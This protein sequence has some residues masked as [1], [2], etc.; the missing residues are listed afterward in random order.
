MK[1]TLLFLALIAIVLSVSA[2]SKE[3]ETLT[4]EESVIPSK[5]SSDEDFNLAD[6]QTAAAP[7]ALTTPVVPEENAVAPAPVDNNKTMLSPDKQ[8]NLVKEYSQA[9]IKTNYGDIKVKFYGADSPLTV[10]NFLNLAKA[11]FYDGIKFHRVIKDFMI[12]GGDPL[13]KGTDTSAW[14]TGGP[15][16][17]FADEFNAHKLVTGSLAMAN[18]GPGTNGSQ[19]FIVTAASTPWLDGHHTNFGE[20]VSGLDVVKKIDAVE[21]GAADRPVKD[22]II[23][24]VELLK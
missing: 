8:P 21:T 7:S 18:A 17:K 2:C 12:Q 16:Y 23:S 19:F 11:G 15:G 9:L 24:G 6:D 14:G 5:S 20:V 3:S 13:S 1:K 4:G 22:V 10:N